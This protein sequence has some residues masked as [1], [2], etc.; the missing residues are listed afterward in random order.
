M[1]SFKENNISGGNF[2]EKSTFS[3]GH[4]T[5]NTIEINSEIDYDQLTKRLC[6]V[7]ANTSNTQEKECASQAANLCNN[8]R[9]SLKNYII[10]NISTFVTGS[11]AA[12]A[13]G[14]LLELIKNLLRM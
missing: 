3:T 12:T 7:F 5:N 14:L 10:D 13:G 8:D 4:E 9:K 6:E 1:I 2:F 11:F